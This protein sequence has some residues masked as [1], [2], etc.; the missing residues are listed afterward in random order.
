MSRLVPAIVLL[1]GLALAAEPADRAVPF[2]PGETLTYDVSWSSYLTAGTATLSVRDRRQVANG[3]WAYYIVGEAKP[4]WLLEKLHHFYYK[5]DAL[6][7]TRTLLPV[8]SSLYSEEQGKSRTKTTLFTSP[9]TIDVE[10]RSTS[11]TRERRTVAASSLDP[12]SAVFLMRTLTFGPG[13]QGTVALPIADG[14]STFTLHIRPTARE[15]L[16]TPL[17]ALPAWRI[18]PTLTDDRGQP[19]T[20]RDLTAWISDDARHLPL[21]FDASLAIGRVSLTLTSIK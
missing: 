6:L 1:A 13:G 14:A 16:R 17:G 19:A 15:T 7:N 20:A 9:T 12:V 11:V 8:Q 3:E 2:A 10:L 18:Q 5:A 4:A 21:R